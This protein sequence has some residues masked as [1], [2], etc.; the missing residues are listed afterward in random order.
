MERIMLALGG[1][2]GALGLVMCTVA[3]VVRLSGRFWI[4]GMQSGSV[5]QAGIAAMTA[6]C[7][8]YLFVLTRRMTS[9]G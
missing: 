1:A 3:V 4:G 8:F 2:A 7:L 9:G 6:G 5:L